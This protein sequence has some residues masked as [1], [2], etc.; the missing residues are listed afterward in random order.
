MS[1]MSGKRF[2]KK[3][4]AKSGKNLPKT[5]NLRKLTINIKKKLYESE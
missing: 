2:K 3:T 5:G 4:G 1:K